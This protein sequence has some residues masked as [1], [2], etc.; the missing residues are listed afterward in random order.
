MRGGV[1]KVID[2]FLWGRKKRG[3]LGEGARVAATCVWKFYHDRGPLRA[4]ALAFT[5]SLG[6]VPLLALAFAV[7]KGM[8][9][10]AQVVKGVIEHLIPGNMQVADK[11]S[12][13]A[14]RIKV[15]TLGIMGFGSF[16]LSAL[17]VLNNVE[18]SFNDIWGVARGRTF[19]RKVT[20]YS[21]VLIV[22]P[23]LII[24]STSMATTA[25][26]SKYLGAIEMVEKAVP[27]LFSLGPFLAKMVAFAAAYMVVPNHR[28]GWKAAAIGG[29]LAALAWSVAE[30]WYI[31]V[32]IGMVKTNAVYGALAHLPAFLVWVYTGWCIVI[33]GAEL[34]CVIELPGRGRY[35]KGGEELWSPR[36][37]V[38]L[39]LLVEIANRYAA[40]T[41]ANDEEIIARAG[42]HP[43]EGR[44]IIGELIA[45]QLLA[46][47]EGE[48]SNLV[49]ARSPETIMM[50][51]VLERIVAR[52]ES[53]GAP[54]MVEAQL[55]ADFGG[56][57]GTVSW[58][59]WARRLDR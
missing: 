24:A 46:Y 35:L 12:E 59:A 4:A 30:A 21:A 49:P 33:M 10:E 9:A 41:A 27:L 20:D 17:L 56:A 40:G 37:A 28:V 23:L 1:K 11:I 47:T 54:G 50:D 36:P 53:E 8:G 22:C 14:G 18:H 48:V 29:F 34:A 5:T 31:R 51:D 52:R 26:V 42:L 39:A 38:A 19:L 3:P 44:R 25:Q 13:Y 2:S 16:L 55:L 6:L 58:A 45:A 43:V 15:S 7:V 57:L 32:G